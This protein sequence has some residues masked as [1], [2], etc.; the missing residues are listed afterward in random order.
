MYAACFA[1]GNP[2]SLSQ[3]AVQSFSSMYAARFFYTT[4]K[5]LA[6]TTGWVQLKTL[7]QCRS[8]QHSKVLQHPG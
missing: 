1:Y 8:G 5:Y 2:A 3:A 6:E 4:Q 7:L